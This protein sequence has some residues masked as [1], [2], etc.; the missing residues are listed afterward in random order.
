MRR[1]RACRVGSALVY[2]PPIRRCERRPLGPAPVRLSKLA[3][4]MLALRGWQ[5]M[6]KRCRDRS[7]HHI[8][9]GRRRVL[10]AEL[11]AAGGKHQAAVSRPWIRVGNL[12]ARRD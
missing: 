7:F 3:Q 5:D 2:R 9:P 10:R 4:E 12:E 6:G 11:R 8:G 1:P